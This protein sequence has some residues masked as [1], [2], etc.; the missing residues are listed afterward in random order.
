[1][2][3]AEAFCGLGLLPATP[4]GRNASG[5]SL[6]EER[7]KQRR[8]PRNTSDGQESA[9]ESASDPLPNQRTHG[10]RGNSDGI[11]GAASKETPD[12]QGGECRQP[13]K[14]GGWLNQWEGP[15]AMR[16]PATSVS[17]S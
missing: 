9:K 1:M 17:A 14:E 2:S 15:R 6:E 7:P 5:E 4:I 12:H 11:G 3:V 13:K 16:P 10:S 8:G